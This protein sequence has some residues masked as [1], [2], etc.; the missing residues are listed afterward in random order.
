LDV[1]IILALIVVNGLFAMTEI[2]LITARKARL[3]AMVDRGDTAAAAALRLGEDPTRFLSTIQIG[4]TSIGILNGILG[5]AAFE[6]PL[7]E[8]LGNAGFEARTAEY[9][10]TGIIVA[11]V[12]YFSIVL[13]ELVPKRLGQ[14][15]PEAIARVV[16]RP[17]QLL[18]AA[19]KPFVKLLTASTELVLALFGMRGRSRPSVTEDE[20]QALLA[21][22]SLA[23]VIEAQEHAMVRNVLRLDDRRVASLMVRRAQVVTLDADAP[24]DD[25]RRRIAES[26]HA[27]FP[28]VKG[29]L[30]HVLGVVSA[31]R[32]LREVL[33]DRAP[34]L[35]ALAR[36]ALFVTEERSGLD[37]LD[38]FRASGA[39]LAF[40]VAR[41]GEVIGMVT[42]QDLMESITGELAP[43]PAGEAGA[44]RRDDGS[45]LLDGLMPVHEVSDRLGIRRLPD[46]DLGAYQTLSGMLV[47]LLARVPRTGESVQWQGWRF[48]VVDMDGHRIDKVLATPVDESG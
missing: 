44:V 31:R 27:R 20:I 4:I 22:G 45:W 14:I 21:E 2:A 7:R 41:Y 24:W 48:E 12:T 6:A 26:G 33:E 25:N 28:L 36:P 19:S 34:D 35:A 15:N 47:V 11:L 46:E 1:G 5:E 9:A 17:M 38:T 43:V 42:L 40:V 3:Q 39:Q 10:S 37:L 18:A 8:W 13:G 30:N 23:G 29:D 16:A 32:I